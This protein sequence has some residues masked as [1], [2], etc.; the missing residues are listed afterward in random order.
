MNKKNLIALIVLLLAAGIYLIINMNEPT[1]KVFFYFSETGEDFHTIV[2][3]DSTGSITLVKNNEVWEMTEPVESPIK[4]SKSEELI[5]KLTTSKTSTL[6]ISV[7]EKARKTYNVTD[8]LATLITIQDSEGNI[9]REAL[10]GRADNYNFSYARHPQATEIY[11]LTENIAWAIKPDVKSWREN[12]VLKLDTDNILDFEVATKDRNYKFTYADSLW[13]FTEND[14]S[15][16]VTDDNATM[17]KLLNRFKS[18]RATDFLDK[19][20]ETYEELLSEPHLAIKI[21]TSDDG[22]K[23]LTVIPYNATSVLLQLGSQTSPLY[24]V[25]KNILDDFNFELSELVK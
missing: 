22:T 14:F 10:I 25:Q 16:E 1:E 23:I 6:P 17:K 11:Q 4:E 8:S 13:M 18:L 9:V 3:S 24:I 21:N 15:Q 2:I 19:E 12:V 20:F 5:T 7:S